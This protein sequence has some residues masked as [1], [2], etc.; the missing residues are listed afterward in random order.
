MNGNDPALALQ[1]FASKQKDAEEKLAKTFVAFVPVA[2]KKDGPLGYLFYSATTPCGQLGTRNFSTV[3]VG[4]TSGQIRETEELF[5]EVE[6]LERLE[7]D[8]KDFHAISAVG[9]LA[10]YA[11][12][13]LEWREKP[14]AFCVESISVDCAGTVI[15]QN[16][17]GDYRRHENGALKVGS[18]YFTGCYDRKIKDEVTE[19]LRQEIGGQPQKPAKLR[20]VVKKLALLTGH[21]NTGV[22]G[23]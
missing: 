20:S 12:L 7:H 21:S 5:N 2:K 11:K 15:V 4:H 6:S 17:D 9:V 16:Y 3:F 22:V 1:A 18:L 8:E 10:G 13:M 23:I 19:L 14:Q